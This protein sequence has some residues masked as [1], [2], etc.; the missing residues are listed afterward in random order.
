MISSH[1]YEE[2]SSYNWLAFFCKHTQSYYA[3]RH[4]TNN[5]A[6]HVMMAVQ[7]MGFPEHT[8]VD[9]KN[10]DTLDNSDENLRKGTKSQNGANRRCKQGHYKGVSTI[11]KNGV[12][13]GYQARIGINYKRLYLGFST[14]IEEAARM[15]DRAAIRYFGEFAHTNFPLIDY[16]SFP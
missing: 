6:E 16:Q 7:I 1:R 12:V 13:C 11:K 4:G 15:Y 5:H 8:I 2:L 3:A 9:H 14:L 10:H